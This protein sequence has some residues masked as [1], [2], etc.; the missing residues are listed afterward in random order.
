[1]ISVRRRR[2]RL[3]PLGPE[4]DGGTKL[5]GKCGDMEGERAREGSAGPHC[6]DVTPVE[7]GI[8]SQGDDLLATAKAR[9]RSPQEPRQ[10]VLTALT[11]GSQAG[12]GRTQDSPTQCWRSDLKRCPALV[13]KREGGVC[14]GRGPPTPALESPAAQ[15]LPALGLQCQSR[16][17]RCSRSTSA[18]LQ[19]HSRGQRRLK[20][21][22][23]CVPAPPNLITLF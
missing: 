8:E 11:W 19:F 16:C 4:S 9:G 12:A 15:P 10:L 14:G 6:G 1:M 2:A 22:K 5:A 20:P 17:P 21:G 13:R 23:T 18:R 7:A 3:Q